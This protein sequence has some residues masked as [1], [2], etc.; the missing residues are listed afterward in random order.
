MSLVSTHSL[1][2]SRPKLCKA[3]RKSSCQTGPIAFPWHLFQSPAPETASCGGCV[4]SWKETSAGLWISHHYSGRI[5][6][7][8]L[9]SDKREAREEEQKSETSCFQVPHIY[10]GTE[11]TAF[12]FGHNQT[13][14]LPLQEYQRCYA[15]VCFLG[16][17][18][19]GGSWAAFLCLCLKN[20]Y[21]V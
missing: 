10:D 11:T 7:G 19:W 17:G 6:Q 3:N 21:E 2:P 18:G 12:K 14:N 9:W 15:E 1:S 8:T 16:G 20:L 5:K 13:L 4:R